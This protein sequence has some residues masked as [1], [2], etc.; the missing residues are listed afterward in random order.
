MIIEPSTAPSSVFPPY[1]GPSGRIDP[2]LLRTIVGHLNILRA[3]SGAR[4]LVVGIDGPT[5]AGKSTLAEALAAVLCADGVRT[6]TYQLDWLLRARPEREADVR[7]LRECGTAFEYEGELHMRLGLARETLEEVAR[8]N[9]QVESGD[10]APRR[11]A[12]DGLY[13]RADGG[14]VTGSQTLVL[15]PGLVVLME[16]H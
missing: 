3:R 2:E 11:I 6:W 5:A 10:L 12:L 7:H 16:G 14:T 9:R 1:A 15:E 13:S 8:Y 4:V